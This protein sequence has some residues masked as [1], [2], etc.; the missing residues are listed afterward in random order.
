MQDSQKNKKNWLVYIILCSDQSL[1]TGIT[2]DIIRR[3]EQH[4]S[5]KGAKYFYGRKPEKIVFIEQGHDR[6]SASQREY[7]IKTF[8]RSKK[9]TLIFEG[10][11]E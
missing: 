11:T 5:K 4:K 8:S 7:E 6:V 2:T 10:I 3:F 1:Y 9:N